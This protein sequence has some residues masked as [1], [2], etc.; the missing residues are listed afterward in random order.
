MHKYEINEKLTKYKEIISIYRV[1]NSQ[2]RDTH[3][4]EGGVWS[5]Q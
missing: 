1:Q 5:P 2:C 3:S 4:L